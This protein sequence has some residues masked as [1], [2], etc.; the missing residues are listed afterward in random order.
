VVRRKL[1]RP[2]GSVRWRE[3]VP[4]RGMIVPL[5]QQGGS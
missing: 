2:Y 5:P 1:E 3:D 4:D